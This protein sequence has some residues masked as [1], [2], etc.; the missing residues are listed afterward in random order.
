M[1]ELAPPWRGEV[2]CKNMWC[3]YVLESLKDGGYYIGCS[4]DFEKRVVHHNSGHTKS[5]KFR[6]PFKLIYK[7]CHDEQGMAYSR[8]KELKSYKGG[9]AFKKLINK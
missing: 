1:A 5:T 9:K 4:S 2:N 8:E 3:V 7:E 6:R